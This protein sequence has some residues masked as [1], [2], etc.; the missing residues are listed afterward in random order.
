MARSRY[1]FFIQLFWYHTA[2]SLEDIAR[3]RYDTKTRVKKQYQ[4]L[5]V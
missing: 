4:D 1:H 5:A 2:H 3:L